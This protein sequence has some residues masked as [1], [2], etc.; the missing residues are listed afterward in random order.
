MS[1]SANSE[2]EAA[3]DLLIMRREIRILERA[4]GQHGLLSAVECNCP[5]L[6]P[7]ANKLILDDDFMDS[8]L[9]LAV[10]VR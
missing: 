9:A 2:R 4:A 8:E 6:L 7:V 1:V 3:A 5:E 10:R